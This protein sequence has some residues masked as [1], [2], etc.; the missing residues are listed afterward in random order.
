MGIFS[1]EGLKDSAYIRSSYFILIE[2]NVVDAEDLVYIYIGDEVG[3]MD[4]LLGASRKF[5]EFRG[6]LK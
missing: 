1:I 2:L 6:A 5:G 4:E 3:G